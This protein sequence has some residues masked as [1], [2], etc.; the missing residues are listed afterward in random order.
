MYATSIYKI[1]VGDGRK[2]DSEGLCPKLKLEMQ[3]LQIQKDFYVI[4]LDELMW[5]WEWNVWLV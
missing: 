4:D 2:L 5:C 3:G 1:E